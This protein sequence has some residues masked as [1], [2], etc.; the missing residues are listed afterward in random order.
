MRP[1][2]ASL[3][4]LTTVFRMTL[5]MLLT[6]DTGRTNVIA[7]FV[8]AV[9]L[10]RSRAIA[11][12]PALV[13]RALWQVIQAIPEAYAQ[14]LDLMLHPHPVER[15]ERVEVSGSRSPLMVF[16]EVFWI[17]LTPHTIA[18]GQNADGSY[19]VHRLARRGRP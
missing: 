18:L 17:T 14:A 10:P 9:L 5:W 13:L 19:R 8:L 11:V 12:S 4:L 16:L 2:L 3:W 6:S 1:Q 15:V 7:G